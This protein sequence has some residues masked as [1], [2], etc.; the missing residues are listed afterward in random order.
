ML[1]LY[2][3]YSYEINE[4]LHHLKSLCYTVDTVLFS[5]TL[6]QLQGTRMAKMPPRSET[7]IP[8]VQDEMETLVS[9]PRDRFDDMHKVNSGA[10]TFHCQLNGML[11][12]SYP[13]L[14]LASVFHHF[15][16]ISA[17]MTK[18]SNR[19]QR[20]IHEQPTAAGKRHKS[21]SG[22]FMLKFPSDC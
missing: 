1:I 2:L 6:D 22:V 20:Q 18:I 19:S 14:S 11:S 7:N 13:T 17:R 16:W 12:E 10:Q 9:D 8:E 21:A 3:K 4:N 5:M 15:N